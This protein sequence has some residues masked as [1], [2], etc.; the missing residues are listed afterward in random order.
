[1]KKTLSIIFLYTIINNCFINGS[2]NAEPTIEG[3]TVEI[4]VEMKSALEKNTLEL[5]PISFSWV[6]RRST[7]MDLK[8]FF[9][10][11]K[12]EHNCGFFEPENNIFMWQNGY[13]YSFRAART[14]VKPVNGKIPYAYDNDIQL[15]MYANHYAIDGQCFYAG[16]ALDDNPGSMS[17]YPLTSDVVFLSHPFTF[18]CGYKYPNS[19]DEMEELPMSYIL[20][21]NQKGGLTSIQKT[22]IEGNEA[23]QIEA[24]SEGYNAIDQYS[25]KRII[26][27][28]L[29][30]QYNYALKQIDIKSVDNKL[31]HRITNDDFRLLPSKKTY[32]PH[33]STIQHYTYSTI[34]DTIVTSSLFTEDIS[35]TEV[36]THK[37]NKKQFD[38]RNKFSSPGTLVGDRVLQNTDEGVIYIVPANPADLDR[39]IEAALSGKDFVPTPLPSTAAIVI[40]WLLCIA[41]IA[42]IL[43]AGYKKFIKK[44]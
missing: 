10:T 27:F 24:I 33:R 8:S 37:I 25:I 12:M 23:F 6:T 36:S 39:V 32:I 28:W 13:G 21:L 42:M 34:N 16:G 40:K 30:P 18:Y 5:N 2:E 7:T 29:L 19:K 44:M 43:Y 35:L 41:G 31:V 17:I 14:S 1:M 20:Y 11:T 9:T 38:L 3:I 4:P 22:R 15:D 26:S